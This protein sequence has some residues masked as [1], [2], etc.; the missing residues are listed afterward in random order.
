[1][2]IWCPKV[3]PFEGSSSLIL[4][5]ATAIDGLRHGGGL[6]VACQCRDGGYSWC[7]PSLLSSAVVFHRSVQRGLAFTT[8]VL[9]IFLNFWVEFG[10]GVRRVCWCANVTQHRVSR[11]PG[12]PP[13]GL[14]CERDAGPRAIPVPLPRRAGAD[15][16][17]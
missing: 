5:T 15:G 8:I 9:S 12:V 11:V 2:Q 3:V 17:S 13:S 16:P 14:R 6:V 10:W 1:M 7:A 4:A